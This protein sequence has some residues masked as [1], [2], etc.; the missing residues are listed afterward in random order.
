MKRLL[1]FFFAGF[2]SL[3]LFAQSGKFD[4]KSLDSYFEK[5]R[6]EWEIP[7]I[8]VAI[9]KDGKTIFAKGYGVLDI[10]KKDKVDE[11]SLFAIA[12]NTKAFTVAA[13]SILVDEGKLKWDDRVTDYLPYFQLYDP[14]VTHEMRIRDLLCHRTGL[15]TFSGDLLWYESTYTPEEI[16]RRARFLKPVY[17]FREHFGYSNIMYIAAG[18]VVKRVSGKT[19]DEFVQTHFLNP[20]KMKRTTTTVSV[21]GKMD[22]VAQPHKV[23][24]GEKA[25]VIPYMSWDNAKAA[26]ALNSSVSEMAEWIKMQLNEGEWNGKRFVSKENID[27][28]RQVFIAQS[29]SAGSRQNYPSKHFQGYGL[30]WSLFDYQGVKVIGHGG[31]ADGMISKVSFVPEEGIGFVILTNSINWVSTA[32][33]YRILDNYF[34]AEEKDW[35]GLFLSYKKAQIARE[36][37]AQKQDEEKRVKNTQPLELSSYT[38]TYGGKLYGK[39]KVELENGELVLRFLKSPNLVGKLTHWHYNT[40]KIEL[41]HTPLLP[42]GKV[43]FLLGADGN[44]K[45]MEV[46]IPNPDFYFYE[47]EFKK[48]D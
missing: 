24:L 30:G 39:A 45:E 23:V 11:N 28:A 4:L 48:L 41:L 15:E 27:L 21:L 22:N 38:G 40:F 20:L 36:K 32:L 10:N 37:E 3:S 5:A 19:W 26:A 9:V 46:R 13:L 8:A 43:N 31:G 33:M 47:L 29:V 34:D 35:S 17:G 44:V 25:E 12:S 1:L 42:S 18:E 6:Q 16:V 14:Y 7:G 2:L